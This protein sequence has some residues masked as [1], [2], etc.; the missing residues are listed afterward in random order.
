MAERRVLERRMPSPLSIAI[1]DLVSA[2]PR[3]LDDLRQQL[4]RPRF[5]QQPVYQ[6]EQPREETETRQ[7]AQ[8]PAQ[9]EAFYAGQLNTPLLNLV[10]RGA[11]RGAVSDAITSFSLT[12]R[13][14]A[15]HTQKEAK[16]DIKEE[17]E[18]EPQT[19]GFQ[20]SPIR[21]RKAKMLRHGSIEM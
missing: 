7:P 14:K 2:R 17:E 13:Q 6:E 12:A 11:I 4:P 21:T 15:L 5:L 10:Q 19:H 9:R 16:K 18:E 1:A 3:I 20:Y 8:P